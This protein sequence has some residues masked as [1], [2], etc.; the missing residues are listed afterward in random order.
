MKRDVGHPRLRKGL[1]GMGVGDTFDGS[2]GANAARRGL[3][4][5]EPHVDADYLADCIG[6]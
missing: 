4:E 5:G 1:R 3:P 2:Y 6:R